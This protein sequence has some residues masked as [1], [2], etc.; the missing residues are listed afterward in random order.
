MKQG[1]LYINDVPVVRERLPDFPRPPCRGGGG[2]SSPGETLPNGVPTKTLDCVGNG[3]YDK[4]NVYTVPGG[5]FFLGGH[6]RN[7]PPTPPGRSSTDVGRGK[8]WLAGGG[9]II[10]PPNEMGCGG[11]AA[12]PARGGRGVGGG[13]GRAGRVG[14]KK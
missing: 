10:F 7:T 9:W 2:G 8:I 5:P 6:H 1:L 12:R 13:G 4:T 11:G 3:Y 14:K